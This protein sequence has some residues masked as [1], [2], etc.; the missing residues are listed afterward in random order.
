MFYRCGATL[1]NRRYVVTAAHCHQK[2]QADAEIAEVVI[3]D[4]DLST[5]PDCI[6]DYY[7][8]LQCTN[9]PVQRFPV[10]SRDVIIHENWAPSRVVNG[11]NDITL[12]R[13]STFAYTIFEIASGVH[14]APICLPWGRLPNG[15]IAKYPGN[16][17]LLK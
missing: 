11:A 5:N 6:K 14:V 1:I 10:S 16:L 8:T 4:H 12:V 9:K 17:Q 13:L 7:G 15:N 3:G 2:G